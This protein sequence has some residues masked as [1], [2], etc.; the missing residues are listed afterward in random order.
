[1][2]RCAPQLLFSRR[3][4]EGAGFIAGGI[5]NCASKE[6]PDPAQLKPLTI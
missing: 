2:R 3:V 4:C 1:M 5:I 6:I